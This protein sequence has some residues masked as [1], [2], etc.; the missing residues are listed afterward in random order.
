VKSNGVK[1][2]Q[3]PEKAKK[4]VYLKKELSPSSKKKNLDFAFLL[5]I[6]FQFI[7]Q[8]KKNH[9]SEK[10]TTIFPEICGFEI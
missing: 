5:A 6:F 7:P 1:N 4:R 9:R 2:I 10:S 8:E 3:N